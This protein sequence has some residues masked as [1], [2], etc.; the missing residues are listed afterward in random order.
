MPRPTIN[1]TKSF[2]PI[3]SSTTT[4]QPGGTRST[5][6]DKNSNNNPDNEENFNSKILKSFN[7]KFK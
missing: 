5:I 7:K 6:N 4:S 3:P 1:T 2:P